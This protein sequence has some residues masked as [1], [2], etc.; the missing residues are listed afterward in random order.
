MGIERFI[1]YCN[2]NFHN[3]E[4]IKMDTRHLSLIKMIYSNPAIVTKAKIS[5]KWTE[6]PFNDGEREV[7]SA[8]IILIDTR[9]TIYLVECKS[10]NKP[11]RGN[12]SQLNRGYV[13]LRGE[14][15]IDPLLIAVKSNQL[16][17]RKIMRILPPIES[18]MDFGK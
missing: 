8:D 11:G 18:I 4:E 10:S 17:K 6:V 12:N 13:F 16:G 3:P 7:Y 14:F 5:Y 1:E 15:G 9:G 2:A